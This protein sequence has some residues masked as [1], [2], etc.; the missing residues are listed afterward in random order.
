M[1]LVSDEGS[2]SWGRLYICVMNKYWQ[3]TERTRK[4]DVAWLSSKGLEELT[5]KRETEE[6]RCIGV[7]RQRLTLLPQHMRK[8]WNPCT[9]GDEHHKRHTVKNSQWASR[10]RVGYKQHWDRVEKQ[11]LLRWNGIGDS[12]QRWWLRGKW[13]LKDFASQHRYVEGMA[14]L[15]TCFGRSL[16]G[17]ARGQD[18]QTGLHV[19]SWKKPLLPLH[20]PLDL[21]WS[22]S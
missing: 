12:G 10:C 21:W 7:R 9:Y 15:W 11:L 3:S 14:M 13:T 6:T 20:G 18:R 1:S 2:L 22:D 17:R 19:E 8:S 16:H 4:R 5:S